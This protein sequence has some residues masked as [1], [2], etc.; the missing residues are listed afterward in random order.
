M[1]KSTIFICY[2]FCEGPHIG[3]L[4]VRV[5]TNA[6]FQM[7]RDPHKADILV[8][9]S[10]GC[11]IAPKSTRLR[12]SV[13]IGTPYRPVKSLPGMLYAKNKQEYAKSRQDGTTRQWWRKFHWNCFYFWNMR[14]NLAM[15]L[16][17]SRELEAPTGQLLCIRNQNDQCCATTIW[18][19]PTLQ[20]T[21][22]ISLTGEHDDLWMH[23]ESYAAII[24]AY[25]GA[26]VLA[27]TKAK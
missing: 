7:V 24:K 5:L 4:F 11:L 16:A 2:G 23:P 17:L 10:G 26:S 22:F 15:Q 19:A 9:H 6:G 27:P 14:R 21:S 12:L 18:Q 20:R 1:S 3:E 25:Y 8:A 13:Y